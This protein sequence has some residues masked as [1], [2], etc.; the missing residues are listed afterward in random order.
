VVVEVAAE[1]NQFFFFCEKNP[2]NSII[3]PAGVLGWSAGDGLDSTTWDG[4]RGC[5]LAEDVVPLF[6]SWSIS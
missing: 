2:I 3:D 4:I 5:G 1:P 6:S